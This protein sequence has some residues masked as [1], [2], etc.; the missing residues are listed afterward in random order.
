MKTLAEMLD[1]SKGIIEIE[2]DE[3]QEETINDLVATDEIETSESIVQKAEE[4]MDT[5]SI[6]Q[7]C[8]KLSS[9]D[10]DGILINEFDKQQYKFYQIINPDGEKTNYFSVHCKETGSEK[11]KTVNG[12]LSGNYVVTNVEEFINTLSKNIEFEDAAVIKCQPFYLSW[13]GKTTKSIEYFDDDISKMIFSI[14]S[15]TP[16]TDLEN[17]SSYIQIQINN[18][19]NGTRSVML[20]Y[21]IVNTG[22]FEGVEI[23][24]VD[25][26]SLS[27]YKNKIAHKGGLL[28]I[29]ETLED[30]QQYVDASKTRMMS[31]TEDIDK[32]VEKVADSL[33][34]EK[35][36]KSLYSLWDNIQGDFKNLFY[37]SVITSIVLN[38]C[39]NLN[40][41]M[42]SSDKISNIFNKLTS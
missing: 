22:L 35:L 41:V 33:P 8:T 39:D 5:K 28:E 20:N 36:R 37:L 34:S 14:V 17:V 13:N 30:V 15:G 6:P 19:Y 7:W 9:V 21:D 31:Y 4:E 40:Y 42:S 29:K 26:F 16:V 32:V 18:S 3:I 2:D 25:H 38:A 1:E 24:Y 23:K 10:K 27:K 11:W 12:L